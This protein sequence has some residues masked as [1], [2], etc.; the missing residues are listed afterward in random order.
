MS[1]SYLIFL[2]VRDG[3]LLG[4]DL[5]NTALEIRTW[6]PVD[7]VHSGYKQWRVGEEV[8]H[9]LKR[10]LGCLRQEAVEEDRVGQ[11][12]DLSVVSR[13]SVLENHC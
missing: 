7:L 4:L 13:N 3:A 5:F 6:G 8:V 11:I 12:A 9:L 2:G 1:A 10:A